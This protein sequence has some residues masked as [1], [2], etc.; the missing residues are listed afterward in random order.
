MT[1]EELLA[2]LGEALTPPAAAPAPARVAALRAEVAAAGARAATAEGT[3][4]GRRRPS[5]P[6]LRAAVAASVALVLGAAGT[7]VAVRSGQEAGRLEYLAAVVA[8]DGVEATADVR[9][10]GVGRRVA[11][12]TDDLPVLPDG[13]LYEVWFVAPDDTPLR[14][15]RISAGTFHPDPAGRSVV[16]LTAAVD[17][18]RYPHLVVTA[19]PGDGQPGVGGPEVLRFRLDP[20]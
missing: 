15:D 8:P 16:S 1:D 17:P 13:G 19:E 18:A 14:R 20:A 6:W 5:P 9:L 7:L 12:R 11:L 2:R 4:S 3:W 10:L